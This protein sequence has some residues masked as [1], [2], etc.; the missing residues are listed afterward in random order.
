MRVVCAL[1]ALVLA[2]EQPKDGIDNVNYEDMT[3]DEVIHM[4]QTDLLD[5]RGAQEH[6]TTA[7]NSAEMVGKRLGGHEHLLD[8][9]IAANGP[10]QDR[11][12]LVQSR[13]HISAE[14]IARAVSGAYASASMNG[15]AT[16]AAAGNQEA[17]NKMKEQVA[18]DKLKAALGSFD[19]ITEK[20]KSAEANMESK[21]SKVPDV[22]FSSAPGTGAQQL[23]VDAD[24]TIK[25]A[26]HLREESDPSPP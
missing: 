16:P 8:Q 19:T 4:L 24:G 23:E 15:P 2:A 20:V 14:D 12:S 7:V 18:D 17:E 13:M 25:R 9:I 5:L 22:V 10:H 11:S 6:L 1:W 26:D 21:M 3:K